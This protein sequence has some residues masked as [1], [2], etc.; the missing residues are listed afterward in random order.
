MFVIVAVTVANSIVYIELQVAQAEKSERQRKEDEK[1]KQKHI[2]EQKRKEDEQ[3][4]KEEEQRK[5]E[6][7]D[8]LERAILQGRREAE[9][10][11]NRQQV[12][13]FQQQLTASQ[14][15]CLRQERMGM[16]NSSTIAHSMLQGIALSTSY[17][18]IKFTF[19]VV[20]VF[21]MHQLSA[22]AAEKS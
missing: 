9:S 20:C 5:K 8:E 14:N 15:Q 11:A 4:K 18:F 21:D 12:Q 2:D 16:I 13:Q 1:E 6:H 10:E 17:Y 22:V 7:R 19:I 3:K